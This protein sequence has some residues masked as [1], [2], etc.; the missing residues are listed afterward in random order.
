MWHVLLNMQCLKS[1]K[2]C[3]KINQI[4]IRNRFSVPD[5]TQCVEINL[6]TDG[7]HAAGSKCMQIKSAKW[8]ILFHKTQLLT[9]TKQ[10]LEQTSHLPCLNGAEHFLINIQIAVLVVNQRRDNTVN[11]IANLQIN[12]ISLFDEQQFTR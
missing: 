2:H 10:R 3:L 8:C 9:D 1:A 7:K 12:T 11:L 5:Q 4:Y 6:A